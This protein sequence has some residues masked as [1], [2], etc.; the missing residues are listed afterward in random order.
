MLTHVI[1][2]VDTIVYTEDRLTKSEDE[3]YSRFWLASHAKILR[4]WRGHDAGRARVGDRANTDALGTEPILFG[5]SRDRITIAFAGRCGSG[6]ELIDGVRVG[7]R[8][9]RGA[10][11]GQS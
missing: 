10:G 9:D 8:A 3:G 1:T 5:P 4:W 6:T 11:R 7:D 2:D